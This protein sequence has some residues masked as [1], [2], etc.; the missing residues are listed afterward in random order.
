MAVT[1]WILDIG[2]W[3]FNCPMTDTFD[4]LKTAL[5]DRYAIQ[6]EIGAGGMATVY[7][8][9]DL[10]H[11]RKVAVKVLRPEL[12]A[13]LGAERFVQEIETTANLQHPHILPLFD[14]GEADSFL[15]YVMPFI[16]GETL[17]DKLNRE[18]QLGIEEA[19]KIATDV[20]DALD[21]A[22]RHNVIHRD[23]KPENILL[24]DGR[25][26]VADFGIALAVSAAAGGR[27]T[28]TGLSLGTPHYMSPEQATAD[29]DITAR[30]D[31]YSLGTVLYEMLTGDPPHTGSSAQQIIMKIIAEPAQSVI[32]LRKSVPPNVAA[33]VA[34]TLE[35]LPA[36]RFH[37]AAKFGEALVTPTFAL[38]TTS[39]TAGVA[40]SGRP[41]FGRTTVALAVVAT[42]LAATTAWGWLRAIPKPVSRYSLAMPADQALA[43]HV[44]SRIAISP[45]GERMVYIGTT[46]QGPRLFVRER[47]QLRGTELPGTEDAANPFFSP[48]GRRVGFF[49]TISPCEIRAVSIAGGPPTT[50]VDTAVGMPGATWARDGHIY[51][52]AAGIGPLMRVLESGGGVPEA[53]AT[54]DTASGEQ[55]H[56]WP[57]ALPNGRGVIFKI[58]RTGGTSEHDIAVLDLA[59]GEHRVLLRGIYAR[60]AASGHL[61]FVTADGTL[62][63][64]PFDQD[65]LAVT[66]EATALVD[67]INVRTAESVDL[68]VSTTGTLL[69]T[70]GATM[71]DP[72]EIVWVGRDGTAEVIDPT[73]VGNFEAVALSPDDTRLAVTVQ[74]A[75]YRQVWVKTV[76]R[77]PFTLLSLEGSLNFGPRWTPDGRALT[78]VS[79][80]AGRFG[81]RGVYVR[82]AD[83]SA[84]SE[85]LASHERGVEVGSITDDGAWFVAEVGLSNPDIVGYRIGGDSVQVPLVATPANEATPAVSPDGPVA[86]VCVGCLGEYGGVCAAIS[87]HR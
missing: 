73:W 15:Y 74:S 48:D 83:G 84:P 41:G 86:C 17:R 44:W 25:P 46:E 23:I 1:S 67:G 69:Y 80:R 52:D 14:S 40:A 82:R 7:L 71:P 68:A 47:D 10:K 70:T 55:Q 2:Y 35:K 72:H 75:L 39:T 6:E 32:E 9:E 43:S 30:S 42:V 53:V 24:H 54:L 22:H 13:V 18:T 5:A 45:D 51:F 31:V 11:H 60:Y 29:K 38:P 19:V 4:R 76:P 33:S 56:N 16:D 3:I 12:A 36:D 64:V 87:Q 20:A 49:T 58:N 59:T 50:I 8:A 27:M 26:M 37:S 63:V 57:D 21:Y 62:M 77:G 81:A 61:V 78:F 34:H 85:P 66:G 79:N 28:E 65:K